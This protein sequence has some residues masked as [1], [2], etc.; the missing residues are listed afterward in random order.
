MNR[1]ST[2]ARNPRLCSSPRR[3]ARAI[4]AAAAVAAAPVHAAVVTITPPGV[5]ELSAQYYK[6]QAYGEIKSAGD[7][8]VIE[9]G[10]LRQS[11][12]TPIGPA[13]Q[14]GQLSGGGSTMAWDARATLLPGI[15]QAKTYASMT[16]GNAIANGGYNAVAS[17]SS[18]TQGLF[19]ATGT[20]PGE[21]IFHFAMSGSA[22]SLYGL[23]GGRMDFLAR[24]FVPGQGSFFDVYNT[25]ALSASAAGNH[26]FTYTGSFDDPLDILFNAR[27]FIVIQD[28]ATVPAGADFTATADFENTFDL[29]SID[30]FDETGS[31]IDGWTP[32]DMAPAVWSSTRTG[33]SRPPCP[34]RRRWPW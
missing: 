28:G 23:A 24:P 21:A 2:A 32:T 9:D 25:G 7:Y 31:P 4:A 8:N 13:V 5:S 16:V 14:G 15:A 11:S 30:L 20:T 27:A 19:S 10:G 17:V 26:T 33:E 29:T 3:L 6:V 12:A 22:S 34:S 1:P 18:R